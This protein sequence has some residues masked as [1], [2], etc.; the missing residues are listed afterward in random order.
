[1]SPEAQQ[2][3]F[4]ANKGSVLNS[5][6]IPDPQEWPWLSGQSA[7]DGGLDSS[8][9]GLINR[10]RIFTNSHDVNDSRDHKNR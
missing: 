2:D 5:H 6:A 1:M 10:N 4:Y 9:F 8:D 3:S 7:F